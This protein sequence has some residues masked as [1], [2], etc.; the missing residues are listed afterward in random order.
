VSLLERAAK[1]RVLL[2]KQAA[3][4]KN[5]NGVVSLLYTATRNVWE[6][7]R[8]AAEAKFLSNLAKPLPGVGR[9][10]SKTV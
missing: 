4:G 1:D 9:K 5:K 10:K 2:A 7:D 6:A 3:A 8:L